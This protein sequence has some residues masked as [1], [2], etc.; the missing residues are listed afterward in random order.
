MLWKPDQGNF[1]LTAD[2][3]IYTGTILEHLLIE[4]LAAFYETGEHNIYRLRGADWN[5]ALIWLQNA[6]RAQLLHVHTQEIS[7]SLRP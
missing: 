7:G 1:Q 2:G 3:K 5:D 6:A 4:Q